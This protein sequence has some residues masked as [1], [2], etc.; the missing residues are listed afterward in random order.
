SGMPGKCDTGEPGAACKD[1]S[2][3]RVPICFRQTC[4]AGANG[5]ACQ[6]DAD[7]AT[8]LCASAGANAIPG[9]C[10]DGKLGSA[11]WG[12]N[13]KQCAAGLHCTAAFP[14]TCIMSGGVGDSCVMDADCQ[15]GKC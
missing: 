8:K 2:D 11:C 5:D 12:A 9:K 10:T 14:G 3:C 4:S 6:V 1:S 13:S 7:C 15:N